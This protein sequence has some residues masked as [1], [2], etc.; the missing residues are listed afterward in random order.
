MYTILFIARE[1]S[2][3]FWALLRSFQHCQLLYRQEFR[4]LLC[5][6]CSNCLSKRMVVLAT[7]SLLCSRSLPCAIFKNCSTAG[8]IWV[9][10]WAGTI[11]TDNKRFWGRPLRT[12]RTR[13]FVNTPSK[14][15][16]LGFARLTQWCLNQMTIHWNSSPMRSNAATCWQWCKGCRTFSV[17]SATVRL[18]CTKARASLTG[19]TSVAWNLEMLM[20]D[21]Y[22]VFLGHYRQ[23][24]KSQLV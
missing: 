14:M 2:F 16:R 9:P 17:N 11:L 8:Q 3:I 13:T 21:C 7:N 22:R 20:H 4:S 5:H 15:L 6:S 12:C 19:S 24:M 10:S 18:K 23:I 1:T